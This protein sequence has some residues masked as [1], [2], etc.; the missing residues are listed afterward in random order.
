MTG[1]LGMFD[2]IGPDMM[3]APNFEG[4]LGYGG[5]CFPKDVSALL[6]ILP[7]RILENVHATNSEL[8]KIKAEQPQEALE[9]A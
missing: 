2:R 3:A 7:H 8:N 5:A 4:S 9:V 1:I 6:K